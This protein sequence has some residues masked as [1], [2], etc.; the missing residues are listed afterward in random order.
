[1]VF[2]VSQITAQ[3][4][5]PRSAEY[6]AYKQYLHQTFIERINAPVFAQQA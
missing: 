4:P 1:L 5:S 2:K 6:I 3:H